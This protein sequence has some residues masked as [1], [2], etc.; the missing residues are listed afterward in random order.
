[1]GLRHSF[2]H[3]LESG[4]DIR[5][6]QSLLGHNSPKA[7]MIYTHVSEQSLSKIKMPSGD[8]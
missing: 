3:L 5:Y 7:T 6:I 8:L 4:T 1:M 2:G